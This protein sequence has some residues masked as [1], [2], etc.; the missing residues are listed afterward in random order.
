MPEIASKK[1]VVVLGRVIV[2]LYPDEVN[3]PLKDVARF[4]KAIGGSAANVAVA[5]ARHGHPVSFISRTGDDAFGR[6]EREELVRF[7]ID[8]SH[9][10]T[11]PGVPTPITFCEMFPPDDFPVLI[12]RRPTAPDMLITEADLPLGLIR[13]ADVYWSTATGLSQ[14]PSRAAHFAAWESR[15]SRAGSVLDLDYRPS[16][17]ESGEQASREISKALAHVDVVIGNQ[18]ECEIAV[19][20]R[21]AHRAADAL[22]AHGVRV[23]IVKRGPLG[24]LAKT[25]EETVDVA[26]I[27][28]PVVNGLGAGDAFGGA[29]VHG[30]L[31][32]WSLTTTLDFANAAGAYVTTQ[33]MCSS[34]MPTSAE[35][36]AVLAGR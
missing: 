21:D 30:M 15:R 34:A 9:V 24:V 31:E 35:V 12:Y 25:A 28:V 36:E 10:E 18:D 1:S 17:W 8:V 7:G 22:L 2:D 32:G 3:V 14:E 4:T 13:D 29:F 6:F 11:A 20:E 33:F 23:A 16:F 5:A 19:G 26:P 27:S